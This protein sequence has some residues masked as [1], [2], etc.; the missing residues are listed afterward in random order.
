MPRRIAMNKTNLLIGLIGVIIGCLGATLGRALLDP[1]EPS[2][3][4]TLPRAAN[5]SSE[6]ALHREIALLKQENF[7]LM[8]EQRAA[9]AK[10][11]E[12]VNTPDSDYPLPKKL[13]PNLFI[14]TM[15]PD[16][17]VAKDLIDFLKLTGSEVTA[18]NTSLSV[19]KKRLKE[20]QQEH[21]SVVSQTPTAVTV[22][23]APFVQEGDA[24][25]AQLNQ[26]AQNALGA[27]RASIFMDF[28]DRGPGMDGSFGKAKEQVTITAQPGGQYQTYTTY[29]FPTG[30]SSSTSRGSGVPPEYAHLFDSQASSD[31]GPTAAGG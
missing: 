11:A 31:S 30:G 22:A 1:F 3:P 8:D 25:H 17:G 19:A 27:D 21:E 14:Q 20:L 5:T 26:D 4:D 15:D 28:M 18:L 6:D 10:P 23:I 24:V 7:R 12:K 2:A 13:I 16:G 9:E 29:Q